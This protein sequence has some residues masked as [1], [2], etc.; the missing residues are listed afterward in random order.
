MRCSEVTIPKNRHWPIIG[1]L[2]AMWIMAISLGIS[3]ANTTS[4]PALIEVFTTSELE[5]LRQAQTNPNHWYP[6]IDLQIYQIDGIQQV[7]QTL[8]VNLSSDTDAAKR[9][10]LQ[11]IQQLDK[12][13]MS[14]MQRAAV[15]LTQVIQYGIDRYPAVV[16]N[17]EMVVY[18][19]TDLEEA[20]RHW[21]RWQ[22]RDES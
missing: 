12:Q 14:Q 13:L 15:G 8:S 18:G 21:H 6:E 10:A 22:S 5:V 3:V 9:I 7:E 2:M 4:L 17:G 11:R 1:G 20:L 19:I 16:F